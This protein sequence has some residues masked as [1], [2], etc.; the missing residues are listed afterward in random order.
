MKRDSYTN[1]VYCSK[2]ASITSL[3]CWYHYSVRLELHAHQHP[4]TLAVD[5][6]VA[7]S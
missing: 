5:V 1:T 2:I 7:P 4:S 6:I 3:T